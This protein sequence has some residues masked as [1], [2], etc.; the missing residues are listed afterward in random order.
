MIQFRLQSAIIG[1]QRG[2]ASIARVGRMKGLCPDSFKCEDGSHGYAAISS[3]WILIPHYAGIVSTVLSVLGVFIILLA[4]GAFKDL[5]KGTAQTII[6]LLALADLGTALGSL[7]G[8]GNFLTYYRSNETRFEGSVDEAC[9]VF[10]NICEIQAFVAF[11]C[12][13]SSS[14]W[15]AVLA[16]HFLIVTIVRHSRWTERLMPLYNIVAWTL[17]TV[18]LLPLL[19][20]GRLGYTPT[21]QTTCYLAIGGKLNAAQVMKTSAIWIVVL[22]C[23]IITAVCYTVIAVYLYGK[24]CR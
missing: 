5:R 14:I 2:T 7:V 17:P 4:Y 1:A 23:A 13:I 10:H 15:S 19:I 18:I 3:K 6:A 20:T 21:Y 9:W 12:G 22:T 8:I 16:V 24:V 11:W